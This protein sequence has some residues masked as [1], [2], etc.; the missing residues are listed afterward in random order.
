MG[1]NAQRVDGVLGSGWGSCGGPQTL[2]FSSE[3]PAQLQVSTLSGTRCHRRAETSDSFCTFRDHRFA[4]TDH[5]QLERR[6][7]LE[8]RRVGNIQLRVASRIQRRDLILVNDTP[9]L[10]DIENGLSIEAPMPRAII[11][12]G[13]ESLIVG[14]LNDAEDTRNVLRTERDGVMMIPG[15]PGLRL[16]SE[17]NVRRSAC[18][19]RPVISSNRENSLAVP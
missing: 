5:D 3:Y 7:E 2:F 13:A 16:P 8:S 4:V 17:R 14:E 9:G 15:C 19:R 18:R 6:A 11:R 12:I 1:G 10:T